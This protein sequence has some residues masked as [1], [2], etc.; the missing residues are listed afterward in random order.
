[1]TR[2]A[3]PV[4]PPELNP[5]RS[6]RAGWLRYGR[7]LSWVAFATSLLVLVG[8]TSTWA[9][10]R[11]LD[12]KITRLSGILCL[13]TCTYTRPAEAGSTEN[14]L[15]VGTD[16]RAGVAGTDLAGT[17]N[18][19]TGGERSD[20]TL[21][22]HISSDTKR[23]VVL[24]FPRDM[25]VQTP[26]YTTK[27]G[28]AV[29]AQPNKFN[30]A[31]AVG[32]PGLLVQQVEGLTG[33]RV[34]HYVAVD[35]AGF[36]KI[37]DALG[38]VNVCLT[39]NI[40]DPGSAD[41][42]G[43]GFAGTKG[44]NHLDGFLALAY[45]RQRDGLPGGDLGRIARQHRFLAAVFAK[46]K[47]NGTLLNPIRLNDVLSAITADINIDSKT[48]LTDLTTL[49]TRLKGLAGGSVEYLTVPL[50]GDD[51]KPDRIGYRS[52]I[53][54]DKARAIFQA[55]ADDQ[56]PEHPTPIAAPTTSAG[57]AA[58]PGAVTVAPSAV[59]LAVQ[60]GAGITGLGAKAATA[61]RGL[62]FTVT[63]TTTARATGATTTTVRYGSNR[64]DSA[65]TVAAAVPGATL[66]ADP[67]LGAD[68]LVL[69]VGTDYTGVRPVTVGAPGRATTA[70][71]AQATPSVPATPVPSASA[72]VLA[73]TSGPD[74]GP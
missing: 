10:V 49:G 73:S 19:T 6:S 53:D 25:L 13:G 66:T 28:T 8:A 56:D 64:G 1:M 45:V 43:S 7:A 68:A 29:P 71:P 57:P 14:F 72:D 47:S 62:G 63:S 54:M 55:I 61:L 60:N 48:S 69:V 4:L 39:A 58:A 41:S 26:G 24:S 17:A 36:S 34:D 32:G 70:P 40:R 42:G 35:L 59:S 27:S 20:T 2:P 37:V 12:G 74:C 5:R 18:D 52:Y 44:I 38:G 22:V 65:R 51:T 23:V 31:I 50:A 16:S 9:Y 15:L 46:L 30:A 3:G 21:L 11:H 67:T 33:L